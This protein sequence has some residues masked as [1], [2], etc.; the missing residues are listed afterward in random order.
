MGVQWADWCGRRHECMPPYSWYVRRW[1]VEIAA[2]QTP[3]QQS[4]MENSTHQ[5]ARTPGQ[6]RQF[7][8]SSIR[9]AAR[10][11]SPQGGGLRDRSAFCGNLAGITAALRAAIKAAPTARFPFFRRGGV[12]S[13]PADCRG[14]F[15]STRGAMADIAAAQ[16]PPRKGRLLVWYIISPCFS[17]PHPPNGGFFL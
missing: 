1:L 11:T 17:R 4:W 13:P 8:N 6:G 16:A 7:K 2:A 10:A 5:G 15:A 9:R 12:Y 3:H 14:D